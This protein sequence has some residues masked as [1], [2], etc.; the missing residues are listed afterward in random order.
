MHSRSVY[1]WYDF[2]G[3]VGGLNSTL[4]TFCIVLVSIKNTVFGSAL[5][6]YLIASLFKITNENTIKTHDLNQLSP[7]RKVRLR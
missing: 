5:S 3:D 7:R 2:L 1:T 6:R 4:W